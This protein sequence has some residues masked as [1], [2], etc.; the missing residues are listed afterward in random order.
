MVIEARKLSKT[1]GAVTAV[2]DLTL[3]ITRGTI[4]GLGGPSASDK[5]TTSQ[6]NDGGSNPCEYISFLLLEFCFA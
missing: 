3:Q 6:D 1:I 2:R 5:S 4:F